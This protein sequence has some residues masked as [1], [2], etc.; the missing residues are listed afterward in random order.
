MGKDCFT[1]PLL[2]RCLRCLLRES[3]SASPE[4]LILLSH[5]R[6]YLASSLFL[7]DKVKFDLL[8]ARPMWLCQEAKPCKSQNYLKRSVQAGHRNDLP[9]RLWSRVCVLHVRLEF[10]C[11][12]LRTVEHTRG[13]A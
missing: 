5:H 8:T 4:I 11:V 13:R 12:L 7:S 10:A 9:E 1:R 6:L 2:A 3:H